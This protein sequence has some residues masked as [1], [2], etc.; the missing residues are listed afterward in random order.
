MIDETE[1]LSR[2]VGNIYDAA[3][4]P[5][6]WP[7]ALKG[8]S[9]FT[10]GSAASLYSKDVILKSGSNGFTWNADP[11]NG[12]FRD[13]VK[14]DPVTVSQFMFDVEQI[15]SIADLIP[16]E[17]FLQTRVYREWAKPRGWVDHLAATIAKSTTSFSLFGIFRTEQQ[18]LVDDE[19]RRRMRLIVPHVRRAALIGNVV[20]LHKTAAETL[21]D[22]F[23]VLSAGV[24]FVDENYRIVFANE[25]GQVML[26]AGQLFHCQ[27]DILTAADPRANRL[28]HDAIMM[29]RGGDIA[30]GSEGIAIPLSSSQER[31]WLAHILPLTASQRR[32]GG[33]TQSAV[34]GVFVRAALLDTRSTVETM[35]K[36]Y[37][38]TPSELRVLAAVVDIGGIAAIAEVLGI[39]EATVKTHLQHLF[40]KTGTRRQVDLVKM[41]AGHL[42]S[43]RV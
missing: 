30:I 43:L 13:Q 33:V 9:E 34:A 21:A 8:A 36:L 26:G 2:L 16:Y 22:G 14:F 38:L 32:R 24:F 35:A 20:D 5:A 17:E 4:E 40:I 23:D 1:A 12:Y 18:G 42:S 27:H 37:K 29:A 31:R 15:Y 25:A 3:L 39:S 41:V 11:E 28:L 7:E 6:L 19:M 10:G